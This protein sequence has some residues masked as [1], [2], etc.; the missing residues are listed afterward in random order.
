M[1]KVCLFLLALSCLF[2]LTAQQPQQFSYQTV[3]RGSDN[4]LVVN[5]MIGIRISLLQGSENGDVVYVEKHTPSTNANG[6]ASIAIGTGSIVSGNFAAINWSKVPY[7]IKT[8]TDPAGVSNYTLTTTSQLLSV[9]YALYAGNG[10]KRISANSD[11]IFLSNDSYYINKSST[12]TGNSSIP[13]GGGQNQVLTRCD[14]ELTWTNN[15]FC[16]GKISSLDCNYTV[17]QKGVF[18][19]NF[20]NYN[21]AIYKFNYKGG[22]AG[23]MDRLNVESSGVYGLYASL[24]SAPKL[25]NSGDGSFEI[26]I[27]GTPTSSGKAN[28]SF[29]FCGKSCSFSVDVI[30][31]NISSLDCN[32]TIVQQ[33]TLVK[34]DSSG[35]ILR[36][37]YTGGNLGVG[38][39]INVQ[40]TGVIGLDA[41]GGVSRLNNGNGSFDVKVTGKPTSSGKANF[42]FT[43]CGKSCSFSLDVLESIGKYQS[44]LTD[45]DGNEYK[46]T[47]IGKQVWMAENLK[48]TRFND[49]T[50]IKYFVPS[51]NTTSDSLVR[52][53]SV[54]SYYNNDASN[55]KYGKLYTWYAVSPITNGNKNICPFG[56]HVPTKTEY[57]ELSSYL[58]SN[59]NIVSK[60]MKQTGII[61]WSLDASNSSLFSALPSGYMNARG[62]SYDINNYSFW[63]TSTEKEKDNNYQIGR[64]HVF[65]VS[66]G[67]AGLSDLSGWDYGWHKNN[68]LSI[69]CIKD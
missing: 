67:S 46:T 30:E 56:W 19:K 29:T 40:S 3:V 38:D 1:Q 66:R 6:L 49:G 26:I 60:K 12:S 4:L 61:N 37:N 27:Q 21:P 36:F 52:N 69:R 51:G 41:Y 64:A 16:P 11:T 44:P 7:F 23:L 17:V 18:V 13:S 68:G 62:Y 2:N 28:F 10:I 59:S 15:G 22:N 14:G 34:N 58:G 45:I 53:S 35:I 63:W 47:L 65:L 31:S 9:P 48:V 8:E 20:D 24:K 43:F 5:K 33:G 39:Y 55:N 50:I 54:W 32:Y 42:V 57:E 25:L